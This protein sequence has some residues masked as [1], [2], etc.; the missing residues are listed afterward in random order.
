VFGVPDQGAADRRV[1]SGG[2]SYSFAAR[3][4]AAAVSMADALAAFGFGEVAACPT[5][6]RSL[7]ER[8]MG[9]E[10]AA[11]DGNRYPPGSIGRQQ[12]LAVI[13][14]ARAIA[15]A[16]G[17]FAT[18]GSETGTGQASVRHWG[19][20]PPPVLKRTP[21]SRPPIP[22]VPEVTA[23]PPGDLALAPDAQ[24]LRPPQLDG[25][26]AVS[27]SDFAY[28][29]GAN[30][31]PAELTGLAGAS[32]DQD[33]SERLLE[34]QHTIMPNGTCR[35]DTG[36]A[37]TI[38]ARLLLGDALTAARRAGV[39]W[40]LIEAASRYAD[41][42]IVG[43]DWVAATGHPPQPQ[44]LQWAE[45]ARDAVGAFVPDLLARWDI[46]P[47]AN[48][49]A[50]ATLAAVFRSHGQILAGRIA[51]LAAGQQGTRVGSCAQVACQLIAGQIQDAAQTAAVMSLW[52]DP[53]TEYDIGNEL[54]DRAMLAEAILCDEVEHL[55]P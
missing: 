16:Q 41:A 22:P 27:W 45:Q 31:V 32:D 5:R 54:L 35:P 40:T 51:A 29:A 52:G 34:L 14:Q 15:R 49:L 17:G 37:V 28:R 18:G 20:G 38:L 46:E 25:L 10:L 21:G 19:S 23:P 6:R 47:P 2:T 4:E 12:E 30:P 3:D 43:A 39:Y 48:R 11:F 8:G 13:R 44:P 26:D 42:V 24:P 53:R 50:L 36:P 9:W 55:L 7:L 33:W 1:A